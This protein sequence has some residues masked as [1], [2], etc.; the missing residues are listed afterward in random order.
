MRPLLAALLLIPST[1]CGPAL[2]P[3]LEDPTGTISAAEPTVRQ[4]LERDLTPFRILPTPSTGDFTCRRVLEDVNSAVPFALADGWFEAQAITDP[5]GE[6]L[7][8]TRFSGSLKDVRFTAGQ[9][10]PTGL[11]LTQVRFALAEPAKLKVRWFGDGAMG[12]ANGTLTVEI[13][14]ALLLSDGTA[15][16]LEVGRLALPVTLTVQQT[17]NGVLGLSL[18]GG[19]DAVIWSWG[20]LFELRDLGVSLEA[21]EVTPEDGRWHFEPVLN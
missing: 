5:D 1:G 4:R 14:S 12:W 10:P 9:L 2:S 7:A 15:S 8:V 21:F 13:R 3:A 11:T 17:A 18:S 19:R 16:P 20:G 6:R